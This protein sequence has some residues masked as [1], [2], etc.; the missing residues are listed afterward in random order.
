VK[1]LGLYSPIQIPEEWAKQSNPKENFN[2]DRLKGLLNNLENLKNGSEL[3]PKVAVVMGLGTFDQ[4]PDLVLFWGL[5]DN[6]RGGSFGMQKVLVLSGF[7]TI[8]S[9][10]RSKE[11]GPM[12][13]IILIAALIAML[14]AIFFMA[15]AIK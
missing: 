5:R 11:V 15:R 8:K 1:V 4:Y 10:E 14:V 2:N 9:K 7:G 12:F 13:N 3:S 6:C